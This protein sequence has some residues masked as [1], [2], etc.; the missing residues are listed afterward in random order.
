MC[1][2]LAYSRLTVIKIFWDNL[3]L[4][5]VIRSPVEAMMFATYFLLLLTLGVYGFLKEFE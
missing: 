4:K 2:Y 3:W 5:I 1:N